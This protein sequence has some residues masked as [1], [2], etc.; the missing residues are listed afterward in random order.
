MKELLSNFK[1]EVIILKNYING[2][3]L[4][5]ELGIDI[6]SNREQYEYVLISEVSSRG[7]RIK[8]FSQFS[9]WITWEDYDSIIKE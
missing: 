4:K 1:D 9:M 7:F 8:K 2:M 6:Y 3:R 5:V